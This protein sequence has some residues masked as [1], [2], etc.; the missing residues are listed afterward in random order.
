MLSA[1]ALGRCSVAHIGFLFPPCLRPLLPFR[2]RNL[3][4]L[5]LAP[6]VRPRPNALT[7]DPPGF[8]LTTI[9]LAPPRFSLRRL[10]SFPRFP[11]P[12]GLP[13]VAP[14][15]HFRPL[16]GSLR[17]PTPRKPPCVLICYDYDRGRA[18]AVCTAVPNGRGA[19]GGALFLR[20]L[21]VD[22][23]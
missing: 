1:A 23:L 8:V 21:L 11:S 14:L 16:V 15:P 7:L 5:C 19:I 6:D 3:Q 9:V 18:Y 4:P 13:T 2:V 12:T 20:L 17:S 22:D 10:P